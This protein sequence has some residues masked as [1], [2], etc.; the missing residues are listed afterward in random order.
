VS[1]GRGPQARVVYAGHHRIELCLVGDRRCRF[2][3]PGC[4]D[5]CPYPRV[6]LQESRYHAPL[7]WRRNRRW[8]KRHGLV[9][10]EPVHG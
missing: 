4:C 6:L 2:G 10:E 3:N 7:T 9:A 1:Y 5:E 8:N